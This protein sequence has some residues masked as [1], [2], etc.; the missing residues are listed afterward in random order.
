MADTLQ[1]GFER[2]RGATRRDRLPDA[3]TRRRRLSA[4]KRLVVENRTEFARGSRAPSTPISVG[5][6]ARKQS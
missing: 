3:A 4:L 5:G 1:H 6:H 2:V